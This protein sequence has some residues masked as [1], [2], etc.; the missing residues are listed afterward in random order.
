MKAEARGL[1]TSRISLSSRERLFMSVCSD[2][3]Q[4]LLRLQRQHTSRHDACLSTRCDTYSR[5]K[6]TSF[7]PFLPVT[8]AVSKRETT[9]SCGPMLRMN[10][11]SHSAASSD[12]LS[13]QTIFFRAYLLKCYKNTVKEGCCRVLLV[14]DVDVD[15]RVDE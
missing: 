2:I 5:S 12:S 11:A 15:T 6:N 8:N 3:G 4:Y 10:L 9:F 7:A 14:F 13:V 1:I